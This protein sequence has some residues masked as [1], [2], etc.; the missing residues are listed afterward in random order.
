MEDPEETHEHPVI[1]LIIMFQLNYYL[2]I[3][4]I[5]PSI[6]SQPIKKYKT[7]VNLSLLQNKPTRKEVKGLAFSYLF[8]LVEVG[9]P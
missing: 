3:T 7:I 9:K 1:C 4:Y 8:Y 2:P 5:T 6:D